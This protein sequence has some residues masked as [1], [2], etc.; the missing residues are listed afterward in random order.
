MAWAKLDDGLHDHP[1]VDAMLEA[2]ELR[3]AAALGLWTAMLSYSSDQLTDGYITRRAVLRVLPEHGLELAAVLVTHGLWKAVDGGWR[4]SGYLDRNPSGDEVRKRRSAEAERKAAARANGRSARTSGGT[5][6]DVRPDGPPDVRRE[7]SE[8][9]GDP[10]PSRPV[11]SQVSADA[12]TSR[13]EARERGDVV[14]LCRLLAELVRG[15]DPKAKVAPDSERWRDAARLLVDRDGRTV[16]EIERVMRWA[17]AD[18]FW[19]A[20]VLS[21]PKLRQQFDVLVLKAPVGKPST[22]DGERCPNGTADPDAVARW[23]AAEPRVRTRVADDPLCDM[24]LGGVHAHRLEGE[25]LVLGTP[26]QTHADVVRIFAKAFADAIDR[27]TRI[28]PCSGAPS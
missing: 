7:S 21:M 14:Q 18:E 9:S 5:A 20:N 12:L 25:V 3:G 4:I 2:D 11:P 28:V 8:P 27:P 23:T 6:G 22:A 15:N 26:P 19:R 13:G 24:W 1:K 10:V 17:L 16:D